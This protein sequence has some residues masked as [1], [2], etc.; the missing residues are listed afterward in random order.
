[1]V[2]IRIILSQSYSLTHYPKMLFSSLNPDLKTNPGTQNTWGL[3]MSL[4]D[5]KGHNDVA[6]QQFDEKVMFRLETGDM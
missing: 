3:M 1:M 4:F 6:S 5:L 2:D